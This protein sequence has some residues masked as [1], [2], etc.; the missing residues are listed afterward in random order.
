VSVP[1]EEWVG[2]TRVPRADRTRVCRAETGVP[3]GDRG[4]G[5]KR[6]APCR[7]SPHGPTNRAPSHVPV[8]IPPTG[9]GRALM[10]TAPESLV[11]QNG[12]CFPYYSSYRTGVRSA[13]VRTDGRAAQSSPT[14]VPRQLLPPTVAHAPAG[15]YC[16][17]RTSPKTSSDA[18]HAPQDASD[19]AKLRLTNPFAG[20]VHITVIRVSCVCPEDTQEPQYADRETS[21]RMVREPCEELM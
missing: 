11:E 14:H 17:P 1:R 6:K 18:S 4:A 12:W 10:R 9:S 16:S 7:Q 19:I 20:Y 15:R 5:E 3:R 13:G 8:R 2:R 21:V